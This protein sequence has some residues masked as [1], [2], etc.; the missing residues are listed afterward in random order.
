MQLH[1]HSTA[2]LSVVATFLQEVLQ[3]DRVKQAVQHY[4]GTQDSRSQRT[5]LQEISEGR[6]SKAYTTP[7]LEQTV[8]HCS[9]GIHALVAHSAILPV[10]MQCYQY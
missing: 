1:L 8:Q 10:G 7:V 4:H 5:W 6:V 9:G 2:T 3:R